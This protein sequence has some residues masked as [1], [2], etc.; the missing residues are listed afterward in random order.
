MSSS[1]LFVRF[2]QRMYDYLFGGKNS[3]TS[4]PSLYKKFLERLPNGSRVLD[5]GVGTGLY[6]DDRDCVEL[7]KR[8]GI[9]IHGIDIVDEDVQIAKR[10]I[11]R[12]CL[13]ESVVAV[14]DD[15]FKIKNFNGYDVILFCESYPVIDKDLMITMLQHISCRG[16]KKTVLFINNIEDN[17]GPVQRFKSYSRFFGLKFQFGRLVSSED[18]MDTF[19]KLNFD[20]SGISIELLSSATLNKVLFNDWIKLKG[21]QFEMK[22][23]LIS[24]NFGLVRK[25]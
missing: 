22:Q 15:L 1:S 2:R 8:K 4:T 20:K 10:R 6:F 21:F 16:F 12:N 24:V 13:S 14:T 18:M 19:E 3:P 17:P 11:A 5:V 23:Y 9:T 25:N 7:I